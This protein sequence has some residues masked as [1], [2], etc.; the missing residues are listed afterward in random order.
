MY[1]MTMAAV[2][3]ADI[4]QEP[5]TFLLG[6]SNA[7]TVDE[8]QSKV[9]GVFD[10]VGYIHDEGLILDLPFNATASTLFGR[11][12]RGDVVI[13]SGTNPD[14]HEY[15]G[16]NHDLPM[17]FYEYIVHV[18]HKS[19]RES[20]AVSRMLASAVSLGLMGGVITQEEFE[21]LQKYAE[22]RGQTDVSGTLDSMPERWVSLVTKCVAYAIEQTEKDGE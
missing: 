20:V 15:D 3:P 6:G 16:E 8:I 19:A 13:V 14:T 12:L 7:S 9:G 22:L 21:Y 5:Y 2:L 4:A 18:M 1:G 17:N 10:A 11:E